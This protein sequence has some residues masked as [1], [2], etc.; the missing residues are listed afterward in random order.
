MAEIAGVG[1]TGFSEAHY[2]SGKVKYLALTGLVAISK[3][4]PILWW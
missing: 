3:Q 4:R 2:D 1:A